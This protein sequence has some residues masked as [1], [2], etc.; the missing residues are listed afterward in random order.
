LFGS[1]NTG[2]TATFSSEISRVVLRIVL[3]EH[4][5]LVSHSDASFR[6][7]AVAL[8]GLKDG[9]KFIDGNLLL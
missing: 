8:G 6:T 9:S 7:L 4:V 1:H 5:L 3:N 2:S